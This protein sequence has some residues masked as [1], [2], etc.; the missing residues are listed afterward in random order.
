MCLADTQ[1]NT[2]MYSSYY[3][4]LRVTRL[5]AIIALAWPMPA[6]WHANGPLGRA[7]YIL[8]AIRIEEEEGERG[9][10]KGNQP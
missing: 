6:L 5:S 9:L 10:R 8:A 7:V 2:H 3:V 1:I 4:I